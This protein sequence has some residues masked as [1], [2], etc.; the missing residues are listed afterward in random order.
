MPEVHFLILGRWEDLFTILI[1]KP[2]LG[3]PGKAEA[4]FVLK[5]GV[6]CLPQ[7]SGRERGK[8]GEIFLTCLLEWKTLKPYWA[9]LKI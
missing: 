5:T 4:A 8:L 7:R 2:P 3:K 1:S 9:K 6:R